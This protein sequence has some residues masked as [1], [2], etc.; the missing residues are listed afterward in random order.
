MINFRRLTSRE[1]D[2]Q[3]EIQTTEYVYTTEYDICCI[4]CCIFIIYFLLTVPTIFM[5]IIF[6]F[7]Y[8]YNC[9]SQQFTNEL[10]ISRW[11]ITNGILCYIN[12]FFL[13]LVK[14][15][16][17]DNTFIRKLLKYSIYIITIFILAWTVLGLVIFFKYYYG[18]YGNENCPIFFYNY[19]L[20][21][22]ILSPIIV[23]LRFAE[24]YNI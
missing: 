10:T 2:N 20:I 13:I 21:R 7:M 14:I 15:V 4:S 9:S 1:N 23:I 17:T 3:A 18:N 8:T 22:I 6:G 5:D 16:Y 12:L 11:L 24:I 19:L